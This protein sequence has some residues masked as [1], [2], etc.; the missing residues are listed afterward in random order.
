MLREV[1]DTGNAV[2][3]GLPLLRRE[4]VGRRTLLVAGRPCSHSDLTWL[5]P[6]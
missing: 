5:K 4:V 6:S 3:D 1:E 2:V